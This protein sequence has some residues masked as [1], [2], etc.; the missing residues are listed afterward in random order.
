M[1]DQTTPRATFE[2]KRGEYG[3]ILF[4]IVGEE[5]WGN[6]TIRLSSVGAK[7]LEPDQK[8]SSDIGL[9]CKKCGASLEES[10]TLDVVSGARFCHICWLQRDIDSQTIEVG[11]EICFPS[12]ENILYRIKGDEHWTQ[13]PELSPSLIASVRKLLIK[14][15]VP[16]QAEISD[17]EKMVLSWPEWKQDLARQVLRPSKPPAE[18]IVP[19]TLL[20]KIASELY[21]AAYPESC[22]DSCRKKDGGTWQ[23]FMN[24]ARVAVNFAADELEKYGRC[25]NSV[26]N[27]EIYDLCHCCVCHEVER[28]RGLR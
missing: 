1:T 6:D 11:L 20:E 27:P 25:E 21:M 2:F 7:L 5:F 12:D 22:A 8:N 23:R 24:M 28:L 9:V 18:S 15:V 17:A 19:L 3:A 16:S 26:A 4:R 13:E 14:P 10:H